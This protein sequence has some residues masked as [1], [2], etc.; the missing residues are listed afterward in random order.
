MLVSMGFLKKNWNTVLC[1][2][3]I[4]LEILLGPRYINLD[5]SESNGCITLAVCTV[6]YRAMWLSLVVVHLAF[7]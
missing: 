3:T 5:F 2:K 7:Q 6:F 4:Y 1:I